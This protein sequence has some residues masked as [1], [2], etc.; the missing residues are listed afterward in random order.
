MK[1]IHPNYLLVIGCLL[2]I[3]GHFRFGIGILAFLEPIP[4]LLYLEQRRS[5]SALLLLFVSLLVGWTI[6]TLKIVTHPIPWFIAP[7]YGLPI[8]LFKALAFSLYLP[9]RGHRMAALIFPSAF[10]LTEWMQANLTPFA[11]WGSMA[12]TQVDN[13]IWMQLLA[14]G[15]PWLLGFVVLFLGFQG[16]LAVTNTDKTW[17]PVIP[18]LLVLAVYAFGAARLSFGE[19]KSREMMTVA[20]VGTNSDVGASAF[21]SQE[22]RKAKRDLIYSRMGLAGQA[23]AEL[24]VW[25]EAAA[26]IL[27]EEEPAFQQEIRQVVDSLN[28]AAI[29]SYVVPL[30]FE[31]LRYENKY[32]AIDSSGTIIHEYLKHEPVPGEPAV[33]GVE[34]HQTFTLNGISMGGA[35]CYDFDFPDLARE[36]SKLDVDLVALPSSDWRGI[37][38]IHTQMAIFRAVEGGYSLIR[39]TR[40]GLSA[41]ADRF[42]R[43]QAMSSDLDETSKLMISQI[44]RES[45][46]SIYSLSGD[47]VALLGLIL[48][49]VAGYQRISQEK[50][51]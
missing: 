46:R 41:V 11:S 50:S 48:L 18:V 7:A 35:I 6:A 38:P 43:I 9:F 12:Y 21:Q 27:P 24:V 23:G 10:V 8:A 13:I 29:I 19:A 16:F 37:D 39:S 17:N 25:T 33:K 15:G 32:L 4:F 45:R 31:P 30:S 34:P 20:T 40:W 49:L 22:E 3:L 51:H 44:P 47:W 5:R 28:I 1:R 26:G 42:G 14:L 36:I 2:I